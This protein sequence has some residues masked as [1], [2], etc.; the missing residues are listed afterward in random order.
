VFCA[1]KLS[2]GSFSGEGGA[3]GGSREWKEGEE[4]IL[5]AI[6][7]VG[8]LGK[9]SEDFESWALSSFCSRKVRSW[10]ETIAIAFYCLLGAGGML[11]ASRRLV[12]RRRCR[13]D[14]R[15]MS[16]ESDS[17]R[18]VANSYVPKKYL[19][20]LRWKG[21]V[22]S[23][24]ERMKVNANISVENRNFHN[25]HQLR[26]TFLGTS[27]MNPRSDRNSSATALHIA[28][29]VYLF[30]CGEGTQNRIRCS[31]NMK[32]SNVRRIFITH[33]HGDHFFGLF[34]LFASLA[35]LD[36]DPD[37]QT[38]SLIEIVGPPGLRNMLRSVLRTSQSHISLKWVVHEL[39][40]KPSK[41]KPNPEDGLYM[42]EQPGLD[43]TPDVGG[44]VWSSIP[45]AYE[46]DVIADPGSTF[47]VAAATISHRNIPTFGYVLKEKDYE[48]TMSREA[49]EILQEPKNMAFFADLGIHTPTRLLGFLKD[50]WSVQ[51]ADRLLQPQDVLGNRK[52]GR[53]VVILGDT[54]NP[55]NISKLAKD[56][57]VLVHEATNA[58]LPGVDPLDDGSVLTEKK[59]RLRTI[60]RGHSTPGMAGSFAKS[61]NAKGLIM[62]HFS[63]RYAGVNV[64]KLENAG[65]ALRIMDAIVEKAQKKFS[66]GQVATANDFE[67]FEIN[68][69]WHRKRQGSPFTSSFQPLLEFLRKHPGQEVPPALQQIAKSGLSHSLWTS[70]SR[71]SF[72]EEWPV[73][74]T[75]G[76]GKS[77]TK[78]RSSQ[79]NPSKETDQ[80]EREAACLE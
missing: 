51:L 7:G 18:P 63:S 28:K 69:T 27:G 62:T 54:N 40:P 22:V 76:G 70:N 6:R 39:H 13:M 35:G 72:L 55:R 29:D 24:E 15:W 20:V 59:V 33:L 45:L 36:L 57:D 16:S 25:P 31:S 75:W 41:S 64:M 77:A 43:L 65:E 38:N 9:L 42:G 37:F 60:K 52:E 44:K 21:R 3:R 71:S 53:K 66:D 10:K 11:V 50:G 49:R 56:A 61:I 5:E 8:S 19:K 48:G 67:C 78:K 17:V 4:V 73:V 58:F 12:A 47:N 32:F 79:H 1:V 14:G 68:G 34:G 26:L 30:D 80:A 46:D 2:S 74:S 23:D